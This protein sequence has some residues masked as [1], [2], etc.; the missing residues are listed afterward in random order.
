MLKRS[1]LVRTDNHAAALELVLAGS[2]HARVA[3]RQVRL[4]DASSFN[5]HSPGKRSQE[6]IVQTKA[7][8]R[9]SDALL[10]PVLTHIDK[11]E[12]FECDRT[13]GQRTREA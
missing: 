7:E 8:R 2:A 5:S 11:C 13:V 3:P 4:V 9:E 12:F 10:D 6:A 1:E